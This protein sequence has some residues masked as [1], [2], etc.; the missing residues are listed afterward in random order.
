[1]YVSVN[2][3]NSDVCVALKGCKRCRKAKRLS[4]MV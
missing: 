3:K 4:W 1:M 2:K